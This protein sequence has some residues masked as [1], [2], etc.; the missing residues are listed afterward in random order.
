[1]TFEG[2]ADVEYKS[3]PKI[4]KSQTNYIFLM[5]GAPVSWKFVKQT[6]TVTS[7]NYLELL[8]FHEAMRE[9]VWLRTMDRI[10]SEQ[11]GLELNHELTILHKD[12]ST[13]MNQVNVGFIKANQIKH[14]DL[15]IFNYTQDLIED[16]QLTVKKIESAHNITDMFT[17]ALPAY[18]HKIL[19][20]DVRM[21]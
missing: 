17:K 7:T 9:L 3:D 8:A 19:V 16:G 2:Y 12:N 11:A 6:V 4:G 1:M 10:I 21:Q 18:T 14:V 5:V 13:C 15:Q 20:H